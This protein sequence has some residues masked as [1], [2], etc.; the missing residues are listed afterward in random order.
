MPPFGPHPRRRSLVAATL[1][2]AALLASTAAA[3]PMTVHV[4]AV[5]DGATLVAEVEIVR[6]T[7]PGE[8]RGAGEAKPGA[9]VVRVTR[10]PRCVYLGAASLGREI[11]LRLPPAGAASGA[12]ELAG[13]VGKA[14]VLVFVLGDMIALAGPAEAGGKT[15]S[16]HGWCDFNACRLRCDDKELA[17]RG[18]SV[19]GSHTAL[20]Q[21]AGL[22]SRY[23]ERRA[24]FWVEAATKLLAVEP[25]CDEA[26]LAALIEGL[27]SADPDLRTIA[28]D[29][30]AAAGPF[31]LAALRAARDRA[32]DP[33]TQRAL[34]AVLE[35]LAGTESAIAAAERLP[36]DAARRFVVRLI[37]PKLAGTLR[38]AADAFLRRGGS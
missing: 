28:R 20:V 38:T 6:V 12:A 5:A 11:E 25:P 21:V 16:V 9:V 32:A 27:A 3:K 17:V 26:G 19:H 30:L 18:E 7:P 15:Y 22:I 31:H 14:P 24:A 2:G 23:D 34:T 37:R 8:A 33:E 13:L 29:R 1:L 10:D 36:D 4:D 35:S